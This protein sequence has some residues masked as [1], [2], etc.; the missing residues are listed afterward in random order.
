MPEQFQTCRIENPLNAL[1]AIFTLYLFLIF[2]PF[3]S[4]GPK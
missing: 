4:I 1:K 3:I 2:A